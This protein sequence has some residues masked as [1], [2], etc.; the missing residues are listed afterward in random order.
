MCVCSQGC[1]GSGGSFASKLNA[2]DEEFYIQKLA[3]SDDLRNDSVR[4]IKCIRARAISEET[5]CVESTTKRFVS[6]QE[7]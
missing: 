3:G 1:W 5:I 4:D 2:K 6:W 7:T